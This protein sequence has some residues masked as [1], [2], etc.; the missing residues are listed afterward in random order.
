M[1][2]M[3][4]LLRG[5]AEGISDSAYR[6]ARAFESRSFGLTPEQIGL[7]EGL[8]AATAVAVMVGLAYGLQLPWLA[9]GAFG[10]FWCCLADPGGPDRTRAKAIGGF[11]VL[12]ALVLPCVSIAGSFG[13]VV[14]GAVMLAL[15]FISILPRAWG[16]VASVPGLL[17]SVV[18]VVGVDYP[19]SPLGAL[20]LAGAFLFGCAWAMLICL[21]IWRI[22]P[23]NPV[24]RAAAS[25][26]AREAS[27]AG[28]FL[29]LMQ[30]G[31]ADEAAWQGLN[32]EHRRAVRLAIERGRGAVAQLSSGRAP[33]ELAVDS[34]DRVFAGMIAL[35]H[36]L[37]VGEAPRLLR[38]CLYMLR[39]A[40]H[41][42]ERQAANRV[43]NGAHLR[44]Q[45]QAL[46]QDAKDLPDAPARALGLCAVALLA[47]AAGPVQADERRAASAAQPMRMSGAVLR[48]AA[49][50]TMAVGV[51]YALVSWMNLAFSYWATMATV[52][53]MQPLAEATWPRS[54]ER[55][56][57]SVGGGVVAALLLAVLP[58]KPLLLLI[59]F[60]LAA[61]A[62]ALKSVNYTL[63]VLFLT[64][65]F[66]L[67]I[68]M[69]QPG[70]G[71]PAA[72]ALNNVIG[73]LVGV[74]AVLWLWPERRRGGFR[75]ILAEAVQANF[76]FA[77]Q[78]L[79]NPAMDQDVAGQARRAAGMASAAAETALS[80]MRLEGRS[81]R[82]RLDDAAAL[83]SALRSVAGAAAVRLIGGNPA[84]AA[85]AE[86][87]KAAE[88]AIASGIR[89]GSGPDYPVSAGDD[90][91]ARALTHARD[92][93]SRLRQ[94]S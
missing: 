84:D 90:D 73:S 25:I 93:A 38:F 20:V 83:L 6:L 69:V 66:V 2:L 79:A 68:D 51:A 58:A 85:R 24:R 72:R 50:V 59:I 74:A 31:S 29:T 34:A 17:V 65:L 87:C 42:A 53:V 77:A 47:Y 32:A 82:E 15:V 67:V 21:V 26:F 7:S 11:A 62:I 71:I 10:A 33:Y 80:R 49:R 37:T 23:H 63:F 76:S 43:F 44:V 40:L 3:Q 1:G 28:E 4:S 81:R 61:C 57:G 30:Q 19:R 41:E 78:V 9:W 18:A 16:P 46:A 86:S 12:G 36:C 45:A 52:M 64:P 56:I 88:A 55:I 39:E 35:G 5:P 94:E 60:P 91:L 89:G 14:G 22:H 54:L 75:A 48:H 13:H 27:M 70:D 8:R 92:A